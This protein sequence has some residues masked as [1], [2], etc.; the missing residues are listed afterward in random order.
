MKLLSNVS[1]QKGLKLSTKMG[2][3]FFS[4]IFT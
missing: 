2:D 4:Q 3:N 1:P